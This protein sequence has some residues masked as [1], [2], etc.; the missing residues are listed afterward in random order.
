MHLHFNPSPVVLAGDTP[1]LFSL[2]VSSPDTLISPIS[3]QKTVTAHSRYSSP[4]LSG[5]ASQRCFPWNLWTALHACTHTYSVIQK[6]SHLQSLSLPSPHSSLINHSACLPK[7]QWPNE[8]TMMDL[9]SS[10]FFSDLDLPYFELS[11]ENLLKLN[12]FVFCWEY[13]QLREREPWKRNQRKVK[14][15][16]RE[17][18]GQR[19]FWLGAVMETFSRE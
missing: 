13:E 4:T 9:I 16:G 1:I 19:R 14:K 6:K 18:V 17:I 2:Q 3:S 8:A 10:L 15:V 5:C 12:V 11:V 7:Q